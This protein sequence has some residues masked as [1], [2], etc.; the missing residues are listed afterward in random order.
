M[1]DGGLTAREFWK[2][3]PE[4]RMKRC[5]ELSEHEAFIMR[6][7]DPNWSKVSV[8]CNGCIHKIS[9]KASCKAFPNGIPADHIRTVMEDP[10]TEC[11]DGLH[12]EK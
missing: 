12:F 10:T 6:L 7:T 8:P 2:L 1:A 3:S 9:G 11:G 4:D 5:G